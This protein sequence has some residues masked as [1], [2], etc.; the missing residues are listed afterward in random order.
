MTNLENVSQEPLLRW[1]EPSLCRRLRG[2]GKG[3]VDEKWE[4]EMQSGAFDLPLTAL[5][6]Q[7]RRAMSSQGPAQEMH[8]CSHLTIRDA[9]QACAR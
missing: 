7:G 6:S 8:F 9:K 1:E 2:S 3:T 4:G 5:H